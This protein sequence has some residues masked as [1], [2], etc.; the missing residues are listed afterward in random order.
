MPSS[1]GSAVPQRLLSFPTRRSSDLGVIFAADVS[2][3]QQQRAFYSTN[4]GATYQGPLVLVNQ[5]Q[6]V[7]PVNIMI[8]AVVAEEAPAGPSI[9]VRSEEHTSELQSPMY[10]VCRLL[11]D[12]LSPSDYS[13]SLHDA[14]PIWASSLPLMSAGRS[15][16]VL[17]T[18]LITGRP[19]KGL[20]CSSINSNRC[21]RST[22]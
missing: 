19:I 5:Q 11:L 4:N 7:F 6:Q 8:R 15:S 18:P 16:S 10:L 21:F 2:G 22:S 12:P 3:P 14:L 17:S 1:A 20:W 9:N 13:L